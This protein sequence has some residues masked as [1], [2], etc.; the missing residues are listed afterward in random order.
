M[1]RP[2]GPPP[3]ATGTF[4]PLVRTISIGSAAGF[5][6]DTYVTGRESQMIL[7][8][9]DSKDYSS[10]SA[11]VV[12]NARGAQ[13]APSGEPMP[14]VNGKRALWTGTN[15]AIEW[16]HDAWAFV[17]VLGSPDDRGKARLLAESL[18]FDEHVQIEVP[19]T[20]ETSLAFDGTRVTAGGYVELE[21]AGGIRI[22]KDGG[23]NGPAAGR[24][25]RAELDAL[26]KSR[27]PAD[28]P[29]TNPLR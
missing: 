10:G 7:L 18:R 29:V 28:P 12:V 5:H 2:S 15:V 25:P 4:D 24:V 3:V 14:D 21:F 11:H 9:S 16:E 19:F 26:V 17:Q 20:V 13:G 27:R 23:F 8:H 6:L 22:G 1:I